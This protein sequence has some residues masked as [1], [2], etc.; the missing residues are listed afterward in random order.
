MSRDVFFA[1]LKARD[2][3]QSS[4]AKVRALFEAAG[5]GDCIDSDAAVAVK[6]HFGERGNDSYVNPVFAR[7]VVDKIREHGGKPFLTDSN[8]L[9]MGS[10]SNAVDHIV[11][12]LEHGFS[13][14]TIAAPILIADGIIGKNYREVKIGKRHFD[15]VLISGDIAD[16]KSVIV[17]SHFKGHEVAG[18][19]GAIKN[20]AMGCAPPAGK[21]EQHSARPLIIEGRCIGC[22]KCLGVCPCSAAGLV[23]GKSVIDLDLCNGCFECMTICP[24]HAIDVDWE[25]EIPL[26]TER[27]VEYAFGA[28]LGKKAGYINFLTHITPDCDC[29]PWSD[30][31]VVPD[32]GFLASRDP[33]AIDA[34]SFDLVNR[35][36][37][38]RE[39]ALTINRGE[40]EDKFRGLRER[41]DGYRQIRYAEEIGL[42]TGAYRLVEL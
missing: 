15:R 37:G 34:A 35:Q 12:A 31:P 16:V 17:L 19:G 21:Q 7:Q 27:M 26:F 38:L 6:I 22:G 32:V 4:A 3:C 14:A 11:I 29:V 9:Y 20:L 24:E 1:G 36:P 39:S 8:T 13:Y 25:T 23:D 18:F 40:G 10:R 42:G 2:P 28:A 33:V 41:T 5:F 30:A